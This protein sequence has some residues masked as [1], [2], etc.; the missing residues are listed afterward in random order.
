V[1]ALFAECYKSHG[2]INRYLRSPSKDT[3]ALTIGDT[4]RKHSAA[5][6]V[7]VI[8]HRIG[9]KG[10]R[11]GGNILSY[12]LVDG[13]KYILGVN[14]RRK[15]ELFRKRYASPPAIPMPGVVHTTLIGYRSLIL[16][17]SMLFIMQ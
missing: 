14:G 9:L 4:L 1:V 12:Y 15:V 17:K 6:A 16:T 8:W 11:T 10:E 13:V 2:K 7:G 5:T 3:V